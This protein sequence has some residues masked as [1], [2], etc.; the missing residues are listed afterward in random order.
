[1]NNLLKSIKISTFSILS[2]FCPVETGYSQFSCTLQRKSEEHFRLFPYVIM[3]F[4]HERELNPSSQRSTDMRRVVIQ[5]FSI[6]FSVFYGIFGI[7]M[8][9]YPIAIFLIMSAILNFIVAIKISMFKSR[10]N[11]FYNSLFMYL[12]F[13]I[14]YFMIQNFLLINSD[15]MSNYIYRTL[16]DLL[17]YS[18]L[19][20]NLVVVIIALIEFTNSK[21]M[22]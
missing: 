6:Y 19:L 20:V 17:K 21:V 11:M 10:T 14:N 4:R 7:Y 16:P 18:F 13:L 9:E 5:I 8:R 12:S 3:D 1:M 22:Y 15:L 2:F